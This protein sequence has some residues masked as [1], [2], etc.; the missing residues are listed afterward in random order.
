MIEYDALYE[1]IKILSK[2]PRHF[3]SFNYFEAQNYI[4]KIL[5]DNRYIIEEDKF[6]YFDENF[7]KQYGVNIIA[8]SDELN[9][10][11]ILIGAHYDSVINSPGANDNA[12]GVSVLLEIS[13][14]IT[15]SYV[16]NKDYSIWYVFFDLEE[17]GMLGSYYL[18]NSIVQKNITVKYVVILEMIGYTNTKRV[19][20]TIPKIYLFKYWKYLYKYLFF[21]NDF[22]AIVGNKNAE[23]ISNIFLQEFKNKIKVVKYITENNGRE[24]PITRL[25]DH[26]H[27]W[28]YN[29]PAI[30]I[31]DTSFIR[32][33]HYHKET[34]TIETINLEF[35][36]N[37]AN[38]VLNA[39]KWLFK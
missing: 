27:F 4:K 15:P 7:N 17:Y 19:I 11:I 30:M 22:I 5:E 6:P 10:P 12:S 25:S 36:T 3:K 39:I 38:G 2:A 14:I 1:H 23:G 35:L 28:D 8:K 9:K 20:T 21:K 32:N 33:E 24:F 31:T 29:I 13:K 34:D 16:A 37:I 18:V 26:V